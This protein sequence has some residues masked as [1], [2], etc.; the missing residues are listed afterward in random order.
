MS[1]TESV[2]MIE[3]PKAKRNYVRTPARDEALRKMREALAAK[4]GIPSQGTQA[5]PPPP[6]SEVKDSTSV[7]SGKESLGKVSP[8][9]VAQPVGKKPIQKQIS[10]VVDVEAEEETPVIVKKKPS[11]KKPT[12]VYIESESESEPEQI[13]IKKKK[14]VSKKKVVESS[15]EESESEEETPRMV[16]Q[17]RP[18]F[19]AFAPPKL[20]FL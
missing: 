7:S 4:R 18:H 14:K 15:S 13:I 16:Q 20:R 12:V 17:Q 1:D 11:K 10:Q 19:T 8:Q 9:P 6:A 5:T 3:K 2:D